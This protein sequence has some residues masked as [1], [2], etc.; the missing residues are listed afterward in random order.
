MFIIKHSFVIQMDEFHPCDTVAVKIS[1]D[2]AQFSKTS[3]SILL[4]FSLPYLSNGALSGHGMLQTY[5]VR[6]IVHK[7]IYLFAF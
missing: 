7:N 6:I 5:V 2:G 4:S 3:K 1:G